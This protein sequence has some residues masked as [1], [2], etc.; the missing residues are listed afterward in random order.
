MR[1]GSL[2]NLKSERWS[3]MADHTLEYLWR[4]GWSMSEIGERM[5]RSRNSVA[6]RIHRLKIS[7]NSLAKK[8]IQA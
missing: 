6:G 8:E 5:G 3:K 1:S 4:K 7:R 2:E